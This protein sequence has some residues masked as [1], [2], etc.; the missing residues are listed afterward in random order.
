MDY[1]FIN[2]SI[3]FCVFFLFSLGWILID[4]CGKHF[5]SILNFL[6]D[7]K[8]PLP[9]N[10]RELQELEQEAKYYLVQD[11]CRMY[12]WLAIGIRLFNVWSIPFFL[13]PR[14]EDWMAYLFLSCSHVCLSLNFNLGYNFWK[15]RKCK[16]GM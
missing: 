15:D 9:E 4:R 8:V 12:V 3:F 10:R 2:L 5:G 13:C 1:E 11:L 16:L 6:R 7:G 14:I